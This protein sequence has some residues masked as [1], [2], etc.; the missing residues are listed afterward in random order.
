MK[1]EN[2]VLLPQSPDPP[3]GTA[4][5]VGAGC[6]VGLGVPSMPCFMDKA[7]TLLA[8]GG[9]KSKEL[10]EMRDRLVAFTRRIKGSAASMSTRFL[11][12]EELY[13]LAEMAKDLGA[14]KKQPLKSRTGRS[15]GGRELL[16]AF[17]RTLMYVSIEAGKDLLG[18]EGYSNLAEKIETVKRESLAE[19][20]GTFTD[21]GSQHTNLLAYL[22]L[23][24]FKDRDT[25]SYPMIVQFNW[26][27]AF[28]RALRA[29]FRND[30]KTKKYK[31]TL[32]WLCYKAAG[33]EKGHFRDFPLMVRPHGGL[34]MFRLPSGFDEEK[35]NDERW[36]TACKYGSK[37]DWMARKIDYGFEASSRGAPH[38]TL[39]VYEKALTDWG[40]APSQR[41]IV[42]DPL[43]SGDYMAIMPPTW[44]KDI[45]SF[46]GQWQLLRFYLKTVRRIVFIGYSLP[47]S[48]L[49][50]RHF[51][52]LALAD[53]DYVPK[54]YV[55]NPSMKRGEDTWKNYCET[56]EPLKREGRLYAIDK[57]FGD[58]A[59][60][61][62]ERAMH[63]AKRV[64]E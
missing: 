51:L 22:A 23:A 50:M 27:L 38:E 37:E 39:H 55:W 21:R 32:P 56:F 53:A 36:F 47:R 10:K 30:T 54:V 2:G 24:S 52:G 58:P 33:P 17:N 1:E 3:P 59:L 4:I 41:Q 64:E 13:G 49:Y 63:L 9:P 62:L 26:D 19:D 11:D 44:K 40:S 57:P 5:V 61:D 15:I 16:Q 60:F 31:T 35:R 6:S 8:Q 25:G 43:R 46:L 12:V 29:N 7:Y 42:A 48:D 28:D 34:Y 14:L 45:N 20:P 18:N